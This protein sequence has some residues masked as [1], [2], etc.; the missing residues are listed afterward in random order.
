M[1][2]PGCG[3]LGPSR[4]EQLEGVRAPALPARLL[5]LSD[6]CSAPDPQ[7]LGAGVST[8]RPWALRAAFPKVSSKDRLYQE[9]LGCLLNSPSS[10][11][12]GPPEPQALRA[13]SLDKLSRG[14]C[15]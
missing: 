2:A 14:F 3:G 6:H 13:G 7:H 5:S 8:F 9:H 4:D 1:E 12:P 15:P 11:P 10:A